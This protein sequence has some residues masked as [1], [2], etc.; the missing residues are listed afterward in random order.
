MAVFNKQAHL[1][2]QKPANLN[3]FWGERLAQWLGCQD[4]MP[5]SCAALPEFKFWFHYCS[6]FLLLMHTLGGSR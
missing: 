1:I 3:N 5:A 2:P 4:E 6:S